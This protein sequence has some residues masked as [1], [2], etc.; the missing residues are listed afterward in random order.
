MSQATNRAEVKVLALPGRPLGDKLAVL[1]RGVFTPDEC[2]QIV[3]RS[4]AQGFVPAVEGDQSGRS[5]HRCII[6]DKVLADEIFRRVYHVLPEARRDDFREKQTLD[7]LSCVNERC[8][9]QRYDPGQLFAKHVDGQYER[10]DGSER[11]HIT[12]QL[13]LNQDFEGGTTRFL[14]HDFRSPL[15]LDVVPETGACLIFEHEL[16][17]QGSAVRR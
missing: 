11:S 17:H 4:E 6:D 1:L 16:L 5:N 3:A 10:D 15:H 12:V 9:I 7:T 2:V 8:R 14:D 13:Y